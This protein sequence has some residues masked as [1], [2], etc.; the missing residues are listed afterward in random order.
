MEKRYQDK[1]NIQI[2]LETKLGDCYSSFR[3]NEEMWFA[4]KKG[5]IHI[6]ILEIIQGDPC[7]VLEHAE[8]SNNLGV[9]FDMGNY[10]FSDYSS[11]EELFADVLK[12]VQEM[13]N[14]YGER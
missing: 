10:Y 2:Y 3:V 4:C 7:V 13:E 8:D 12:D 5:A 1:K 9:A 14:D 6:V 11:P